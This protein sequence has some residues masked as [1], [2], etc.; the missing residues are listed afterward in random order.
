MRSAELAFERP[1][2]LSA[3]RP[4]EA[5]GLTRDGIRLLVSDGP[6]T[7]HASFLDLP[8]LLRPGDLLVVNESATLPASL[9][10]EGPFGP[11]R[12][13]ISTSYGR[14]IH[15]VEPRWSTARPGPLPV[16]EGMVVRAG[17]VA[18]RFVTPYP[19]LP[20]LWFVRAEGDLGRSM[21]QFGEPIRYGY[22]DRPR[23]LSDYQT[24]FA[25][26]PGSAEMPSAGRP[27][28]PRLLEA[29]EARGIARTG[30]VLHCGVSSL[31]VETEFVESQPMV[32]EP[33]EVPPAAAEAID[34]AHRQGGRV[35]AVGTTVV[36]AL[37]SAGEDGPVRPMRGFTRRFVG[38]RTPTK[39]VDGLLTGLHDSRTSHLALLYGLAGVEPV[40]RAYAAAVDAGY[41]WHEF[42]DAHLILAH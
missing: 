41:L 17:G 36:R 24:V 7:R 30:I 12:L 16:E 25:R 6:S 34:V 9:A 42:G 35:I 38:P 26:V 3:D 40:R 29:L 37:E 11:F 4:P 27:F 5:R 15:L 8:G 33:F 32:P 13:N 1:E 10:A 20:R 18:L 2:R 19:G 22:L 39:V 21:A 28:T 23:P 14:G 31:E